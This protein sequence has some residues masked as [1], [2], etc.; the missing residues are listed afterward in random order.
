MFYDSFGISRLRN[1]EIIHTH[2]IAYNV[3]EIFVILNLN[4]DFEPPALKGGKHAQYQNKRFH[5]S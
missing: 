2:N 5:S 4:D 3:N 1:Q